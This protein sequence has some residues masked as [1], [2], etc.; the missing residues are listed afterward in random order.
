MY[1]PKDPGCDKERA[2][3]A[4]RLL[5]PQ[6]FSLPV[7]L[8]ATPPLLLC[9]LYAGGLAREAPVDYIRRD[10]FRCLSFVRKAFTITPGKIARCAY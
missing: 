1:A 6:V 8:A 2:L 7:A 9:K 4:C 10:T 3:G 5:I